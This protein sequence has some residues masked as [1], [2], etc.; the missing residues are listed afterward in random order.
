MM[1]NDESTAPAPDA[2]VRGRGRRI[3]AVLLAVA[4]MIPLA[5]PAAYASPA[6]DPAIVSTDDPAAQG[7]GE[8]QQEPDPEQPDPEQPDP[9]PDPDPEPE[10]EKPDPEPEPEPEPEPVQAEPKT[11][12]PFAR[13][14]PVGVGSVLSDVI[15][16]SGFPDDH[17]AVDGD[18]PHV[19]V[20]LWWWSGGANFD[21]IGTEDLFNDLNRPVG[22]VEPLEDANHKPIGTWDYPA[23]NGRITVGA[24]AK[25]ASGKAVNITADAAGWYLFVWKFA[26]DDRAKATATRFDDLG[27]AHVVVKGAEQRDEPEQPGP[28]PSP[29][30]DPEPSGG[31]TDGGDGEQS[32]D[33][34]VVTT[35]GGGEEDTKNAT[36]A[37]KKLAA[38]KYS[39]GGSPLAKTGV[40]V[41]AIVLVVVAAL[42]VGAFMLVVIRRHKS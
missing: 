27:H 20:S 19:Q 25:D 14:E 26:G 9:D 33:G 21:A 28:E 24:G 7:D 22:N 17:T 40:D 29:T 13:H 18:E 30:P 3:A 16:V 42:A 4:A 35:T 39:N 23:V 1:M 12:S 34:T 11:T 32:E 2:R 8:E 36:D 38:Q 41:G 6:D 31:G 5:A 10:P 37:L 15:D